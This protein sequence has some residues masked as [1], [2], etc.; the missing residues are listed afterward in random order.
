MNTRTE[1][2]NEFI[3][4]AYCG[5]LLKNPNYAKYPESP[6]ICSCEKAKKEL[7]L[8]DELKE[9]YNSKLADNIIDLKVELYKKRLKR[10]CASTTTTSITGVITGGPLNDPTIPI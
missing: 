6:L 9:L 8:Y 3:Y 1:N 4:C 7:K 5:K 10:E 2:I